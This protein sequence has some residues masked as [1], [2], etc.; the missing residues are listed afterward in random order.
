MS[1]DIKPKS[2]ENGRS[3]LKGVRGEKRM[4]GGLGVPV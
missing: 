2:E 3:Q 4:T 1:C